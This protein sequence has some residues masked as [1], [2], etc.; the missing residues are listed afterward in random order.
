MDDDGLVSGALAYASI[1]HAYYRFLNE[2]ERTRE[3]EEE[4]RG[5]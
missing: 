4:R 3:R 1:D 2:P 5:G